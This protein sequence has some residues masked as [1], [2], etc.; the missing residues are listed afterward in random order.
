MCQ[1]E[2]RA[3]TSFILVYLYAVPLSLQCSEI[4]EFRNG[5]HV[6]PYLIW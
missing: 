5:V 3:T 1:R 6:L 4:K 2:V